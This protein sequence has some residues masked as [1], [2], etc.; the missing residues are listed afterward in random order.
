[1][2]FE[3]LELRHWE[4]KDMS[5]PEARERSMREIDA[6]IKHERD[7]AQDGPAFDR[8]K[9]AHPQAADAELKQAIIDAVTFDEECF[10][11]FHSDRG[12]F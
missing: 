3:R 8:L 11:N 5:K 10:R 6:E 7:F 4:P 1:V 2:T 9:R 12:D